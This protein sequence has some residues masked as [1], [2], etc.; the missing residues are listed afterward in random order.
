MSLKKFELDELLYDTAMGMLGI[1]SEQGWPG[2]D[3]YW[4]NPFSL[5]MGIYAQL[6]ILKS[7]LGKKLLSFMRQGGFIDMEID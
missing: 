3:R 4:N 1:V 2:A 6:T 5:I 7:P